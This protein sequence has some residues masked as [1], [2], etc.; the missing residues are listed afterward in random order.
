LV[1]GLTGWGQVNGRDELAIPQKVALDAE[2][3][4][5]RGVWFDI[6]ILWLTFLKVF[7]GVEYRI[8]E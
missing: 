2:Y 8:D 7:C 4:A 3:L 1:P 6:E 5:L